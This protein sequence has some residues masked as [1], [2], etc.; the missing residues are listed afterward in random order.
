MMANKKLWLLIV[1]FT[2]IFN[3]CVSIETLRQ[4]PTRRMHSLLS[5][6]YVQAEIDLLKLVDIEKIGI[7]FEGHF[8]NRELKPALE[9]LS[10]QDFHRA[11][12]TN[13]YQPEHSDGV[14][15]GMYE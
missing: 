3:F 15:I 6:P 7:I 9:F 12:I 13:H 11:E 1:D 14:L 5:K 8:P 10:R 4:L 2:N